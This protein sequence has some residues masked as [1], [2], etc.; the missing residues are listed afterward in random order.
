[1]LGYSGIDTM[2]GGSGND[3][4]KGESDNDQSSAAPAR[5]L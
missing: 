4:I 1:M 2:Y 5:I 3:Y